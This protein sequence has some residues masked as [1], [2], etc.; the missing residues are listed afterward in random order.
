MGSVGFFCF[1]LEEAFQTIMFST[2]Q[3]ID[4]GQWKTV[5][6]ACDL[7]EQDCKIMKWTLYTVGWINP[8]ALISY[9]QYARAGDHYIKA[10]RCKIAIHAPEEL[11]G[12]T[13]ALSVTA[14]K[15]EVLDYGY[16]IHGGQLC[17]L[18][19]QIPTQKRLHIK[20]KIKMHGGNPTIDLRK[21]ETLK[22]E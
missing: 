11:I 6:Q 4:V 10:L 8:L 16:R 5:A 22:W 20:G 19:D 9:R 17:I 7:M 1:I 18:V 12:K 13:V 14:G 21:G 3:S 15:I 2:W